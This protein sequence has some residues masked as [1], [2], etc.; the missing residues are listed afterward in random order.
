MC[1]LPSLASLDASHSKIV[2]SA[3]HCNVLPQNLGSFN[4]AYNPLGDVAE[5]LT[6]LSALAQLV[7]LR[8]SWCDI[9]DTSFPASLLSSVKK[10]TFSKLTILDLEETRAT[11]AAVSRAFSALTQTIDFE[12]SLTDAR[13]VPTGTLA[14]AVDK[15]IAREAWEVEADRHVHWTP[16]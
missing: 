11:Q 4:L 8:M 12:V 13:A 5:L 10:P 14:V 7:D 6:S 3:I 15:R 16:T 1:P 2:S 9:D